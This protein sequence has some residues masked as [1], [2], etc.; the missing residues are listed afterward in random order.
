M[1]LTRMPS[2]PSEAPSN[3]E[4]MLTFL[5]LK[6]PKMV[7]ADTNASYTV[8]EKSVNKNLCRAVSDT[9]HLIVFSPVGA[10]VAGA[11]VVG[12]F[13]GDSDDGCANGALVGVL[14]GVLVGALVG[15]G[16]DTTAP[17]LQ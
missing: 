3:T 8:C 14:V 9:T 2:T 16:E 17:L 5:M 4:R 10:L 7:I 1:N 13:V 11:L 15:T 12:V 6:L